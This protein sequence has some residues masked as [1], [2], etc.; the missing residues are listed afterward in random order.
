M[1]YIIFQKGFLN[2]ANDRSGIIN[3]LNR[4]AEATKVK[5]F[6]Y[7]GSVKSYEQG[8]RNNSNP[9]QLKYLNT[10][11]EKER[12]R[13]LK[14]PDR[15]SRENELYAKALSNAGARYSNINRTIGINTSKTGINDMQPIIDHEKQ[16]AA[17]DVIARSMSGTQGSL[18]MFSHPYSGTNGYQ[19]SGLEANANSKAI[20]NYQDTDTLN[21]VLRTKGIRVNSAEDFKSNV[22]NMASYDNTKRIVQ[23]V[24]RPTRNNITSTNVPPQQGQLLNN[25]VQ[26]L[27]KANTNSPTNNTTQ[28]VAPP[29]V[30]LLDLI[31]KANN[32]NIND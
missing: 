17:Q 27:V 20:S 23:G 19:R 4:R 8:M 11:A 16:H 14:E 30:N 25:I 29:K 3:D 31:R 6:E 15:V 26:G 13:A 2:E 18:R 32:A 1:K 12:I 22:Q 28:A 5:E 21:K 9:K 24:L 10:I 7:D